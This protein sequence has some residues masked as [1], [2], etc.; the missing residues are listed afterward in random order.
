MRTLLTFISILL[1]IVQAKAAGVESFWEGTWRTTYGEI[2]LIHDKGKIIGDYADK[3]RLTGK[4]SKDGTTLRGHYIRYDGG[5]GGFE[6]RLNANAEGFTG[7]WQS[8]GIPERNSARW[9]GTKSGGIQRLRNNLI[10]KR[11]IPIE[12]TQNNFENFMN[13]ETRSV[14]IIPKLPKPTNLIPKVTTKPSF[15]NIVSKY[16]IYKYSKSVLT[17]RVSGTWE[18]VYESTFGELSVIQEGSAA[19]GDYATL[20]HLQGR[21]SPDGNVWR[22]IFFRFDGKWGVFEFT[23]TEKSGFNGQWDFNRPPALQNSKTWNAIYKGTLIGG[24]NPVFLDNP[25]IERSLFPN[26]L[27]TGPKG[28]IAEFLSFKYYFQAPPKP[29][30]QPLENPN[31]QVNSPVQGNW[32]GGY[33][34]LGDGPSIS[35]EVDHLRGTTLLNVAMNLYSTGGNGCPRHF[36][37]EF[38]SELNALTINSTNGTG[39]QAEILGALADGDEM[40]VAFGLTSNSALRMLTI[41]PSGTRTNPNYIARIYNQFRGLDAEFPMKQR[42]HLCDQTRCLGGRLEALD[43]KG[44]GA[45]GMLANVTRFVSNFNRNLDRRADSHNSNY[46]N[47]TPAPTPYNN[48]V[49]QQQRASI[50]DR[51]HGTW[52]VT[53]EGGNILGIVNINAEG[54]RIKGSGRLQ[55]NLLYGREVEVGLD[56]VT[57]TDEAVRFDLTYFSGESGEQNT[58][59]LLLTLPENIGNTM[60]GTLQTTQYFELV[61][62]N[63]VSSQA[64]IPSEPE[65]YDLPGIGVTGPSYSIIN[66][67]EGKSLK[68]RTQPS[69]NS[70][71]TANLMWNANQVIVQRCIPEVDTIAFEE[72][73]HEGKRKLLERTW[74]EV[75]HGVGADYIQG[76]MPGKYL[77]PNTN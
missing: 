53:D 32:Y 70:T 31:I 60:R 28:E 36:H 17:E 25:P 24:N 7:N 50:P 11:N 58:Q 59:T 35:L 42:P 14:N 66:V 61:T 41:A 6:F 57:L 56:E 49:P 1:F 69:Q 20:G 40:F 21:I 76:F 34:S 73:T 33:D 4:W 45:L 8:K 23:R 18:G 77:N 39:D 9:E 13:F 68:L 15:H 48:S 16:P 63:P 67:P 74:C 2:R 62:F 19:Y 30:P 51:I 71:K 5:W 38:C 65:E 47:T 46:I 44:T 52:Q 26:S 3:G 55:E 72:A 12:L 43:R 29:S 64:F 37:L 22:G 27:K 10:T 75:G 54:S